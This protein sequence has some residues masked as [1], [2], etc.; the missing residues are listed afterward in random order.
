MEMDISGISI[1]RSEE[2]SSFRKLHARPAGSSLFE[3]GPGPFGFIRCVTEASEAPA[4]KP[5][6]GVKVTV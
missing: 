3:E 5:E 6:S 4:F 1:S 2:F